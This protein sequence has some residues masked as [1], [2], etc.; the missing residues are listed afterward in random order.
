MTKATN[1][2]APWRTGK[3]IGLNICKGVYSDNGFHIAEVVEISSGQ[4]E[5]NARLIAAAPAGY[6]IIKILY[7]R[8]LEVLRAAPD[9][10]TADNVLIN[11]IMQYFANVEGVTKEEIFKREVLKIA[12]GE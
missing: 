1:T 12:K 6:E 3:T 11:G 8:Y 4:G 9:G 5:A 10:V 7:V 2:P